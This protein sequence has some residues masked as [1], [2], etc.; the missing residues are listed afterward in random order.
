M[1]RVS[2]DLSVRRRLP[3]LPGRRKGKLTMNQSC[4]TYSEKT[5]GTQ[6]AETIEGGTE[7]VSAR[8]LTAT[9]ATSKSPASFVPRAA[10]I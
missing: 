3:Y 7:S 4:D 2:E 6:I 8:K 5:V 9:E 1:P 10:S